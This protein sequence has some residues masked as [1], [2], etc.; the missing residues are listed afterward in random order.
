MINAFV[1]WETIIEQQISAQNHEFKQGDNSKIGPSAKSFTNG[2]A[3]IFLQ[4]S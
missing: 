2:K 4:I 1:F 3:T